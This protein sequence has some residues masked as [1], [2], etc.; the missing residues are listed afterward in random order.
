MLVRFIYPM[1]GPTHWTIAR[2]LRMALA[3]RSLLVR[4]AKQPLTTVPADPSGPQQPDQQQF[5]TQAE[6][7]LKKLLHDELGT[8]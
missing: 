8:L 1:R 6:E 7:N 3:G 4:L 5:I 2:T